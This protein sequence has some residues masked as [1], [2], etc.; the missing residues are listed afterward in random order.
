M[1]ILSDKMSAEALMKEAGMGQEE[2]GDAMGCSASAVSHKLAGRRPIR[3]SEAHALR[4]RISEKLGRSVSLDELFPASEFDLADPPT[5]GPHE[6]V[7]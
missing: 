3:I 1:P 7:A 6:K 5:T 4:A 2:A